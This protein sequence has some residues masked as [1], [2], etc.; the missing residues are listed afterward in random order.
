MGRV[1]VLRSVRVFYEKFGSMKFISHL[2]MNRFMIRMVRVSKIP[3]WYSEGL[4]PH[5]YITFAL[6]LS[7]GFESSYEVMDIRLD[8]DTYSN[9]EVFN[10]LSSVMPPD[11]NIFKVSDPIM[12]AGE[13]TSAEFIVTFD[14]CD[15]NLT[16]KFIEFLNNDEILIEKKSKK[17]KV[18]TIDISKMIYDFDFNGNELKLNLAAGGN[19]NLNPKLLLEAFSNVF[20]IKLSDYSI[21]RIKIYAKG[22][23]QFV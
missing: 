19:D 23:K 2:D 7:L 12:K 14:D 15:E 6:P 4:N 17:G 3:V 20:N 18:N 10:S 9:E 5:P 22:N 1:F 8:D 21:K 11:I 13:I 16:N